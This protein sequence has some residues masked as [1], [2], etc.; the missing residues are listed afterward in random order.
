M[1]KENEM[2]KQG[3]YDIF[4]VLGAIWFIVGL[5]VYKNPAVWPLGA[6]FL[7]VGLIGKYGRR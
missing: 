7:I 5:L 2:K 4:L 1:S 6:I 3:T